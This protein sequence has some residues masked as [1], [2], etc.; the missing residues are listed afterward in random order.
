[1]KKNYF[2]TYLVL[3]F[4]FLSNNLYSKDV[5]TIARGDG[6]YPPNEMIIDGELVGLH[7]DIINA[8]A[9]LLGYKVRYESMPW[10]RAIHMVKNGSVDAITYLS[11]NKERERFIIYNKGNITSYV[12]N[13]FFTLEDKKNDY[14]YNGSLNNLKGARIGALRGYSY[15]SVFDKA[16]FLDKNYRASSEEQLIKKLFVNSIDIGVGELYAVKYAAKKMKI[17][18]KLHY[19]TPELKGDPTYLGFSKKKGNESIALK[20]ANAM[21]KFKQTKKYHEIVEKWK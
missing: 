1:M 16:N 12:K 19:M 6:Y 8:V 18:K 15:D 7:I 3:I 10:N 20:F 14:Q 17:E 13:I 21:N 4:I 9:E 11:R 5:L 2:A